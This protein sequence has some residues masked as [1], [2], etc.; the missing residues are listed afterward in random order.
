[1]SAEPSIAILLRHIRGRGSGGWGGGI[2]CALI[3]FRKQLKIR[4]GR[5][6]QLIKFSS[7]PAGKERIVHP[8]PASPGTRPPTGGRKAYRGASPALHPKKRTHDYLLLP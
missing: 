3:G 4:M 6:T 1:M 8:R 2:A 5:V 7:P